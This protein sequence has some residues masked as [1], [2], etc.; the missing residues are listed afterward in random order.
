M[1]AEIEI[2]PRQRPV[3]DNGYLE[4]LTKAIFQAG[5]SWAVIR[6]KWPAFQKAFDQFDIDMVAAYDAPDLDRLLADSGIVRNGRKIMAAVDNARMFQV[7]RTEYGGFYSYLRSM[8]GWPYERRREALTKRF[9]GLG[10][11]SCFVFLWCVDEA[12]PEWE[13]R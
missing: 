10:R 1:P 8:D 4:E 7:L 12:V 9:K 5:F 13:N 3:N 11:T 2:P 6:K